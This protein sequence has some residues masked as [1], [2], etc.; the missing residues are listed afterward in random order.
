MSEKVIG[1]HAL[2]QSVSITQKRGREET[3]GS[4]VTGDVGVVVSL[5]SSLICSFSKLFYDETIVY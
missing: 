4:S 5:T 2:L 3:A 1:F